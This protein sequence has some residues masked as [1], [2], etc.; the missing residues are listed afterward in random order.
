MVNKKILQIALCL[1]TATVLALTSHIYIS[2]GMKPILDAMMQDVSQPPAYSAFII[3]AAYGTAVISVGLVVFLYYHTQ[4]LL[5]IES[6]LLKVLVIACIILELKGNL[7]RQPLMNILV[8]YS[9]GMDGFKPYVFE[10]LNALDNWV[11]AL[12]LALCLVYLCPKKYKEKAS[13]A[14]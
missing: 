10:S 5:P 14:K 3:S 12:L 6:N 8:N 13:N 1:I 2:E 4:H 7:I 9:M 11:S